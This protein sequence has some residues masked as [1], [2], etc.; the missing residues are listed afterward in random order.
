M[1]TTGSEVQVKIVKNKLAP[2]FKTVQFE[3]E[4]G[5]GICRASELIELGVKHKFIR[6][7][8]SFYNM[9]GK[10]Y[11]GKEPLKKFLN[12]NDVAREELAE[13]LR[14]VLSGH[15]KKD[16]ETEANEEESIVQIVSPDST[17][18]E[19]ITAVGA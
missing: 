3:L 19:M 17:D 16:P 15:T 4:F 13:K 1:Q 2:P 11:H 7:A 10:S 5:K 12:E 9:D 18:E 6:K 14:E 8:S